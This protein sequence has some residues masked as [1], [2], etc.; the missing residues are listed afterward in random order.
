MVF[1]AHAMSTNNSQQ[2]MQDLYLDFF[3]AEPYERVNFDTKD[4]GNRH[5]DARYNCWHYTTGIVVQYL[6]EHDRIIKTRVIFPQYEPIVVSGKW[7]DKRVV[8]T[9]LSVI[10]VHDQSSMDFIA[11]RSLADSITRLCELF[12]AYAQYNWLQHYDT[13][14][15]GNRHWNFDYHYWEYDLGVTVE[16]K[17]DDQI[18]VVTFPGYD[19]IRVNDIWHDTRFKETTAPSAPNYNTN[20]IKLL[21]DQYA[22]D[23]IVDDATWGNT[24][25]YNDDLTAYTYVE[26]GIRVDTRLGVVTFPGFEGSLPLPEQMVPRSASTINRMSQ[27]SLQKPRWLDTLR[28]TLATMCV[29]ALMWCVH[30]ES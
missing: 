10:T 8:D 30:H 14:A 22:R 16:I 26:T 27:T 5:W 17:K 21:H 3:T 19:P 11:A 20:L 1:S 29:A 25:R 23:H 9:E 28:S 18:T 6:T 12:N 7:D 13:T 15:W 24:K 4:W 2:K